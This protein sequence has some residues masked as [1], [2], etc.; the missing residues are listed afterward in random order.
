[1]RREFS[2]ALVALA[3]ACAEP[4]VVDGL[5]PAPPPPPTPEPTTTAKPEPTTSTPEPEPIPCSEDPD[6]ERGV[7]AYMCT[8]GFALPTSDGTL[9]DLADLEGRVV[10]VE[11]VTMWCGTCQ[12]S[13]PRLQAYAASR[14]DDPLS[15]ITVIHEDIFGET[16]TL[17]DVD[18]WIK[19]YGITHPVVG[20][21]DGVAKLTWSRGPVMPTPMTYILD[22]YGIIRFFA[23][24]SESIDRYDEVVEELLPAP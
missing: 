22:E 6:A 23:G 4:D 13:A 14:A 18:A 3:A 1:M 16:P 9:L 20:D 5:T 2:I 24:G 11:F 7:N 8:P 15:I 10:L 21:V 17:D 19:H 12:Q